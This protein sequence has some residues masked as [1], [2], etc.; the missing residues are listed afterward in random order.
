MEETAKGKLTEGP[1]L[2][3]LAGLAMPIMA[4]S[5][6]ST[7]YNITDMA[8]IGSLGAKAV[9]GVGVAGMYVWL[10]Q[11]LC[12]LARMGG[13]V[14]V[15]QC[16]GRDEREEAKHYAVAALQLT[17]VFGLLF[18]AVC[19]LFT[20]PLINFFG[21]DDPETRECARVY[22]KITCGLLVFSYLNITL[23]GL[24]TA[25][26]DSKTPFKANLIGLVINMILDPVLILGLGPFPRLETVG[27]AIA[28]VFAQMVV[29]LVLCI[30]IWGIHGKENVLKKANLLRRIPGKYF[31]AICRIGI[32]TALQGTIYCMISMVLTRM[33]AV[34]GPGAVATQRVG[35]Q[36]ESVS[37]NT[38]DGFA[39][40]LN[41]FCGQNYGAGHMDRV[42]KGYRISFLTIALWGLLISAFFVFWPEPIARIFFHEAEVIPVAV[43]YLRIIGFGE[44]FMCVELMAVGAIS[45]LG[46]TKICSIFTICLTGLRIP[47]ALLLSRTGLGL[48]GIWWALTLTSM[49]KGCVMHVLFYR[50]CR[51]LAG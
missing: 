25:Q 39:T 19:L 30:G 24:F 21:I 38:A 2:S 35:G 7:A 45:G 11:G 17:V 27:A 40:A 10:S 36:I 33:V 4:S 34:F 20:N 9:A 50:Q 6:L 32:P 3:V 23:T 16:I 49:L 14:Y 15:A 1:I 42:K 22:M 12:S 46:N 43:N 13:Q 37:W 29:T 18:A 48:D 41:A 8:W 5:F 44:A 28:T 47:L 26:G 31:R 51:R